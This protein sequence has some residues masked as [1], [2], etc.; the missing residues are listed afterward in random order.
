MSE[1]E[2]M[3]SMRWQDGKTNW[4][5]KKTLSKHVNMSYMYA[6][7]NHSKSVLE[8]S[9]I[10]KIEKLHLIINR[11]TKYMISVT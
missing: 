9:V 10:L 4:V 5:V 1:M 7:S 8:Q 3:Q 11:S 2:L 6:N